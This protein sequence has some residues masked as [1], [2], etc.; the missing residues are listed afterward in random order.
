MTNTPGVV[1][2]SRS[3]PTLINALAMSG[4][5]GD[6]KYKLLRERA[7]KTKMST[8]NSG[9]Y[10]CIYMFGSVNDSYLPKA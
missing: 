1:Q 7:R 9:K 2:S 10:T 8:E 3:I 4:V 6:P 5:P